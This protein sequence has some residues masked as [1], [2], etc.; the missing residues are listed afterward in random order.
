MPGLIR[1]NWSRRS[2]PNPRDCGWVSTWLA[3]GLITEYDL[4]A[5]LAIQNHLE[6]GKPEPH[7]ISPQVVRALPASVA[8]RW[9]VL[10]FRVAAGEL[11]LAGSEIPGE[12]MQQ[13]IGR[14][15]LSRSAFA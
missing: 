5:A 2:P 3:R 13:D 15:R 12:E 10:P 11:Y 9:R 7:D 1:S 8:R 14:F 6:L 4:Y